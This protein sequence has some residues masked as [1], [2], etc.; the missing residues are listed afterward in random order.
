MRGVEEEVE[1]LVVL[2]EDKVEADGEETDREHLGDV[3]VRSERA[4][5]EGEDEGATMKVRW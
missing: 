5:G 1:D 3:P 2:Y 4:S